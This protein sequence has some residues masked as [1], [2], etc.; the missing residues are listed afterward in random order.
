[1]NLILKAARFAADCHA[2]QVRKYNGSPY[3]LH[4]MRVAG[5][6]AIH[7]L[8]SEHAVA[9]AWLHDVIEDCGVTEAIIADHF[10]DDVASM[11]YQLT[12]PSI[13]LK[14]PRAERK[15]MDRE[16]IAAA[17][18]NARRIKLLDRIDNLREMSGCEDDFLTVYQRESQLLL[19]AL[20]GTDTELEDELLAVIQTTKGR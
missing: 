7:P 4:P 6:M 17:G 14:L 3:I 13:G 5:R 10:G 15:R 1:M 20:R 19:D 8:A 11:A 2:G 12:N 16:H 9:A 18:L